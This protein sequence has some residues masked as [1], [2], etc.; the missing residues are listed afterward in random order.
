MA[1]PLPNLRY[2]RKFIAPGHSLAEV[3]AVVRRHP[4]LFR[5]AYPAR[6]VNS[7]YLDSASRR[8]YFDHVNGAPNRVKTRIRWYGGLAGAHLAPN[9]E[10]K[11]KRGLVSGKLTYSLPPLSVNGGLAPLDLSETLARAC[12]PENLHWALR[13]LESAVVVCYLRHYFESAD[14]R[15]RLTV[16]S[17]LRFLGVHP[18]TGFMSP[19]MTGPLPVIVE[20]KF[21]PQMEHVARVTNALPFRLAR[22]SK[23]VLGLEHVFAQ[24]QLAGTQPKAE[25]AEQFKEVL[26]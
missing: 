15:F 25:Q 14:G 23:Y 24:G 26:A 5:E 1:A 2:E 6:V 11:L 17:D 18:N 16:D 20:L 10:R 21:D 3:L 19:V 7:L 12:L 9:L 4:A 22:C 8:D 13:H